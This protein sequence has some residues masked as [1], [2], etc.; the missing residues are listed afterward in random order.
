[1][2]TATPHRFAALRKHFLRFAEGF[3]APRV[4]VFSYC[5]IVFCSTCEGLRCAGREADVKGLRRERMRQRAIKFLG[6]ERSLSLFFLSLAHSL[7]IKSAKRHI[8]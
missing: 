1:M 4:V 7:L 6:R 8:L 3:F 2:L 5:A